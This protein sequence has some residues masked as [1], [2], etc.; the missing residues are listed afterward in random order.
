M[1]KRQVTSVA[2]GSD[3]TNETHTDK[4]DSPADKEEHSLISARVHKPLEA[5]PVM[6]PRPQHSLFNFL[7]TGH[8]CLT[9][10]RWLMDDQKTI[11][12]ST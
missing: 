7:W 2:S 9:G 4:E 6:Y 5:N 3:N 1:R 11:D 10:K 12:T 8:L